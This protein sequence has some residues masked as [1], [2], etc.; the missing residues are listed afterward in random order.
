[1]RTRSVINDPW[2]NAAIFLGGMVAGYMGLATLALCI[3]ALIVGIMIGMT[4]T[5]EDND[6]KSRSQPKRRAQ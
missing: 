6:G 2:K 1:M 5:E 3:A 4:K